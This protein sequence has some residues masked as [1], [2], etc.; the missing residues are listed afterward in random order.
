[1]GHPV[2][3]CMFGAI[4][5]LCLHRVVGGEGTQNA[6][7]RTDVSATVT[8]RWGGGSCLDV[9]SSHPDVSVCIRKFDCNAAPLKDG[10][11]SQSLLDMQG[12]SYT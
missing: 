1:M 7:E 9:V 11:V 5:V 8:K 4:E 10:L 6:D 2:V 12:V 3:L